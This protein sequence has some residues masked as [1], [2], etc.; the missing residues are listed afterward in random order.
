MAAKLVSH[1]SIVQITPSSV[2]LYLSLSEV[3][4]FHAL[5]NETL[6]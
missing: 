4:D 5:Y 3:D 1:L 2:K 6:S